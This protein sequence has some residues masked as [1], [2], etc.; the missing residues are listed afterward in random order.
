MRAI[1]TYSLLEEE[2]FASIQLQNNPG[3]FRGR[4]VEIPFIEHID[5]F[6]GYGF[7]CSQYQ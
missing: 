5:V 3:E 1:D 7:S 4:L 2:V 6:K